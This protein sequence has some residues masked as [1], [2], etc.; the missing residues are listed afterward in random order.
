MN[1]IFSETEFKDKYPKSKDFGVWAWTFKSYTDA[2]SKFIELNKS[3]KK[4][5]KSNQII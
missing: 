2:Y 3:K 1:R 4:E 5:Q